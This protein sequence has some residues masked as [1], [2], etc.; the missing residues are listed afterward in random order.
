MNLKTYLSIFWRRK[1]VILTTVAMTLLITLVGTAF[2]KPTYSAAAKVQVTT[3]LRGSLGFVDYDLNY[4]DRLMNTFVEIASSGPVRDELM[5]RY[6]LDAPPQ[7]KAEIIANTEL[8]KISVDARDAQL[9]SKL[10]NTL[11]EL[12]ITKGE[13]L[14]SQNNQHALD[15]L[16]KQMA[17]VQTEL[18]TARQTYDRLV[19]QSSTD[20]S[21]I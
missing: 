17:Q 6:N 20:V 5:F 3:A 4:A 16:Q 19:A 13:E 14:S 8:M 12:L 1:W 7:V 2:M 21:Q 10:A 9:A 18:G 15:Y 11:A